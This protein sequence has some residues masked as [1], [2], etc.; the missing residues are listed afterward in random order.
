MSTTPEESD[1][2]LQI[3]SKVLEIGYKNCKANAKN[4]FGPYVWMVSNMAGEDR[5]GVDAILAHVARISNFLELLSTDGLSL[6][7]WSNYRFEVSEAF[8]GRCRKSEMAALV[9]TVNRFNISKQ[10]V[11]DPINAADSRI[12]NK[13]FR[14][15]EQF[16]TFTSLLGGSPMAALMPILQI[17]GE[18]KQWHPLAIRGGQS[19]LQAHLLAN[20]V[21]DL[22]QDQNYFPESE[23]RACNVDCESILAGEADKSFRHFC[24]VQVNRIENRLELL[25]QLV[26]QVEFDGKRVL[27]SLLAY[28]CR[29]LFKIKA[30]PSVLFSTEGPITKNEAFKLKAKHWMGLE[31][32]VP[33]IPEPDDHH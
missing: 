8:I 31:G 19:I 23:L 21:Q 2:F 22:R 3:D 28:T 14:T 27:T 13:T 20:F 9:D 15:F 16:D 6:D 26:H 10:F 33:V 25:G 18:A 1:Q 24:R 7:S 5:R 29:M 32:N 11:F 30:D 17:E 4:Y 12:R